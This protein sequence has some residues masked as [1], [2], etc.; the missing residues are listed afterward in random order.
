MSSYRKTMS[1]SYNSMYLVEDNVDILRNIVKK[2]QMMPIKFADGKMGVDLFTASAVTQALDKVNDKNR[3]KLT[4]LINTGKK[5]AFASIAKVVM[6]SENDPEIEEELGLNESGHTDVASA[7]NNVKVAMSAIQKMS[8][9]LSKL[10]PEDALPS[11]WTNKVQSQLINWMVWQ[12][13]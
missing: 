7:Q 9:E 4:K 3:E 5:S 12:I 6:K 8:G 2:K 1:E 13:T 10:N 11:W